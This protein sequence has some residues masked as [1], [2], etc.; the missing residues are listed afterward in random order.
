MI[1]IFV[2]EN[3]YQLQTRK[4]DFL[5]NVIQ[6]KYH[7]NKKRSVYKF[8]RIFSVHIPLIFQISTYTYLNTRIFN[9]SHY[10][11]FQ[12]LSLYFIPEQ[13]YTNRI[14]IFLTHTE[15]YTNLQKLPILFFAVIGHLLGDVGHV[16]WIPQQIYHQN[17]H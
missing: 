14:P 10:C 17:G 16:S 9:F 7:D 15:L 8:E 12:I 1:P 13:S 5:R 2:H 11:D 3:D 6:L 4:N